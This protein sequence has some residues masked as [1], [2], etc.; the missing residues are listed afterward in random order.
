MNN[1][2]LS[3]CFLLLLACQPPSSRSGETQAPTPRPN[4]LLAISDDQSWIHASAYGSEFIETPAFDRIAK[5][6]V[7]FTHA[8]T[9]SPGCSPSRAALLTGRNCWQL[10]HAGT[11]ASAFDKKYPTYPELL[12]QA[13][14]WVGFTGKGWGP[15]NFKIGGRTEN[16]AGPAFQEKVAEVPEGIHA[17]DYAANFADFLEKRQ[18]G[19][20]FCF[21][22]GASEPHRVFKKGIGLENGGDP[23]QVDVPGFLPDHPEIR[24]D[25]L[26]YGFEIEWFDTHLG[27]M[28][29]LLEAAGEL[30]NT[31]IIVTSDNGM[32][33]PRAKANAYEYGIHM[34]LAIRWGAKAPGGRVVGDLVGLADLAPTILEAAG[35]AHPGEFP[36]AA[37]SLMNVLTSKQEGIVDATRTA[38]FSARERHSS[39]RYRSLGYPQR[40]I[41]TRDF[42]YIRNF[43]PERWPS[44]AP[45]KYESDGKTLGP[46][47]GGYH[48]I[49]A[50]PTLDFLIENRDHPQMGRFLS[51]AVAHRP[52]EELYDMRSDPD[53]LHNLAAD[54]AFAA[55]TADHRAQL[56]AYLLETGDPRMTGKGDIWESYPRYSPLRHF[57][58]PE[59]AKANPEAVPE[60]EWLE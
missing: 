15:G 49:D 51:L 45:Q 50:C 46:M 19:Q 21:W 13:G 60:V 18:P 16:P 12:Q 56:E 55:Q 23:Q 14:Y 5:E 42:L 1:Y 39:V 10:E 4:I 34:P 20:P 6:G 43:K 25:L 33:F 53:C 52:A 35:V 11:H 32:A 9:A 8:F 29:Q 27:R 30:E 38:A 7:L 31:L 59:W 48:D 2:L 17:T 3:C 54:P 58:E 44:G 26:D 28:I 57:P 36:M 47:H 24:S 22:Y 41:R 40:A 37:R